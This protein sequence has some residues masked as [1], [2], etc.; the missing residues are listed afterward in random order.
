MSIPSTTPTPWTAPPW[1]KALLFNLTG[2]GARVVDV[3]VPVPETTKSHTVLVTGYSK[4]RSGAI[5]GPTIFDAARKK[6]YLCLALLQRGD[7]LQILQK[8][9]AVLYLDDN[10]IPGPGPIRIGAQGEPRIL[11]RTSAL[12][13]SR[14]EEY[15]R[16][17]RGRRHMQ[18][19]IAGSWM[20]L[21]IWSNGWDPAVLLMLVNVGGV[22][23]AGQDLGSVGYMETVQAL[24]APLGRL[25]EACQRMASFW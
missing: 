10:S 19:T 22:D 6:G 1:S 9:D 5:L 18:I 2:D 7:T 25:A 16:R 13:R 15:P 3:R 23:S 20:R 24:D 21:L 14:F 4:G 11:G 12:W 17:L 8:Q